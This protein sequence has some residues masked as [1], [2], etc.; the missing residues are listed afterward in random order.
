MHGDQI[1]RVLLEKPQQRL[2]N[3]RSIE[4]DP[5]FYREGNRNCLPQRAED[6]V[7]LFRFAQQSAAGAFSVNDRRGA[8]EVQVD[9]SH[10]M[11]LQFF[12]GADQGRHIIADHLRHHRPAGRILGNRL[13]YVAFQPRLGVHPKVFRPI[14][15]RTA[16]TRHQAPE[17]QVSH[18][19]HR[20]KRKNRLAAV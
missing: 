16:V 6:R 3:L 7:D 20:R 10:G 11:L 15:V 5:R 18:V 17:R 19:L 8:S 4:T 12:R 9:C 2:E 1:D 14:H 13:Q